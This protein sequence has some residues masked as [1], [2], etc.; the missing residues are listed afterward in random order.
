MPPRG[1][2]ESRCGAAAVGRT[3]LFPPLSSGGASL[4]R[5]WLR[6]HIPLIGMVEGWRAG[7]PL[8]R[9]TF[10][11]PSTSHAACAFPALLATTSFTP[12]LI[13]P[14]LHGRLTAQ[15]LL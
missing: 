14:I 13:V 4:V 11:V 10:P 2:V 9:D 15:R 5:P 7:R 12:T 3:Y 6:F 1:P 8:D